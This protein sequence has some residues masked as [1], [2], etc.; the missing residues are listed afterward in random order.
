MGAWQGLIKMVCNL[1]DW[2]CII[3]SELIGDVVLAFLIAILFYFV[4]A[5]KLRWGFDNTI[6]FSIPILLIVGLAF[7]GFS[8]IY[9]FATVVIG[10]L[11]AWVFNIM[12]GNR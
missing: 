10:L 7:A 12:L 3:I 4:T 2:R 11:M 9:A 6:A 1:L 8:A 5:T